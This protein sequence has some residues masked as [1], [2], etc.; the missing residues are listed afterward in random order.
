MILRQFLHT[1]P[2]AISYLFGCGGKACGAVVDP[3]GEVG[4]YLDAARDAGLKILYVF[5][6]HIH[7]DH[8]STGRPLAE[9]VGAEYVLFA[10]AEASPGF[11]AVRDR[12][13]LPLGSCR[14]S[15]AARS[16]AFLIASASSFATFSL[17]KR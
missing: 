5:D 13:V 8:V 9:A 17:G 12:E 15:E 10:E 2:V 14:V 7:A 16:P 4:R 3:L 11:R 6:T 1:D